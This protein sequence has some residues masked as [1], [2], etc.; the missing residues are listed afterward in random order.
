MVERKAVQNASP[1]LA[2]L[3]L[4]VRV[5]A[6]GALELHGRVAVVGLAGGQPVDVLR[7]LGSKSLL[8]GRQEG[9][10][11]RVPVRLVSCMGGDAPG[12][13]EGILKG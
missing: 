7:A 2:W 6:E 12:K 3:V 10:D 9:C 11:L 13:G 1:D 8:L 4:A 5:P